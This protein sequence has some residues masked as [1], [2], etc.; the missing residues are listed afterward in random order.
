M[1]NFPQKLIAILAIVLLLPACFGRGE[2]GD[3]AEDVVKKKEVP[4]IF[5]ISKSADECRNIFFTCPDGRAFFTDD[6]GCGCRESDEPYNEEERGLGNMIRD[7]LARELIKPKC[8]GGVLAEF[9]YIAEE[10]VEPGKIN[11]DVWAAAR[12]FCEK[13]GTGATFDGPVAFDVEMTE[14]SRVVKGHTSV[15]AGDAEAVKAAFTAKAAEWILAS[16]NE[17]RDQ[18]IA[19]LEGNIQTRLARL[20][21]Q[22]EAN[23]KARA[24]AEELEKGTEGETEVEAEAPEEAEEAEEAETTEEEAVEEVEETETTE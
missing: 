7:K 8:G 23:Q 14:F 4:K 15:S 6:K 10:E 9:V 16:T 12:E 17:P 11:Y 20:Q 13:G 24:L 18:V 1:K 2:E 21:N 3:T 5:Y 19:E 22:L